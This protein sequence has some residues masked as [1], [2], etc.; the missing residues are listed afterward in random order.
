MDEPIEP[1]AVRCETTLSGQQIVES[2][3][4]I[5]DYLWDYVSAGLRGESIPGLTLSG[6][7]IKFIKTVMSIPDMLLMRKIERFCRGLQSLTKEESEKYVTNI[8]KLT[9]QREHVFL[10]NVLNKIEEEEK[11]DILASVFAARVSGVL[12]HKSYRR[13]ALM[14][15]SSMYD[16]LNFLIKRHGDGPVELEDAEAIGLLSE[17]WLQYGGQT[18]GTTENEGTHVYDFTEMAALLYSC[19]KASGET[20]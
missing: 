16:D 11:L 7:T 19:V 6:A 17:G 12:D 4:S 15:E 20:S 2:V 3:S 1:N 10:L 5:A 14:V 18:W 9:S 13:L 8:E